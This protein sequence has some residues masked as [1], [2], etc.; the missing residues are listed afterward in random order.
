MSYGSDERFDS[1]NIVK[2]RKKMKEYIKGN[3][4]D[5]S[6]LGTKDMNKQNLNK[7][8]NFFKSKSNIPSFFG[9]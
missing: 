9:F 5:V 8:T 6:K 1:A 7:F 3:G 2:Q 4:A